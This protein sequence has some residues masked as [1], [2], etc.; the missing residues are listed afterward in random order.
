MAYGSAQN[1]ACRHLFKWPRQ[2]PFDVGLAW[3]RSC[4]VVQSYYCRFNGSVKHCT[5]VDEPQRADFGFRAH[6][7]RSVALGY[8]N[9][10]A[11]V[12]VITIETR[13]L[14]HD[15]ILI[16][17]AMPGIYVQAT[18]HRS[19]R[20]EHCHRVILQNFAGGPPP[21]LLNLRFFEQQFF[22]LT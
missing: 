10:V 16:A 1:S 5:H 4:K 15:L 13:N 17:S 6:C 11:V 20:I 12:S 8:R 9:M 21:P 3:H 7:A 19:L 22:S 2:E 18:E 14:R